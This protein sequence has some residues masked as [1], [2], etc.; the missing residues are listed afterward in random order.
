MSLRTDDVTMALLL[1]ALD[2]ASLRHQAIAS[3]LANANSP[4][5]R[6]LRVNFEQQLGFARGALARADGSLA[7]ADVAGVSPRLE[8]APPPRAGS[9]AVMVD[10]EMVRLAQNTVQY[11]AL[12]KGLSTRMS[13]LATAISEGRR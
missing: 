2:A 4:G 11:Q 10:M 8:Q 9:A 1:K 3:N 12:L 6:A 7:A 13:I 5:Y